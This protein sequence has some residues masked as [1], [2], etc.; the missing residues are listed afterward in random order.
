MR[1]SWNYSPSSLAALLPEFLPESSGIPSSPRALLA[2]SLKRPLEESREQR[3][4]RRRLDSIES[5][6]AALEEEVE[7]A[8]QEF[9]LTPTAPVRQHQGHLRCPF[10]RAEV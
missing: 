8:E 7:Q 1:E 10:C 6:L 3:S 9:A 2:M 5:D 4:F